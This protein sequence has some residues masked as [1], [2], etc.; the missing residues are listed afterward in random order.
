MT[1]ISRRKSLQLL[2]ASVASTLSGL[3]AFA[4]DWPSKPVS[5]VVGFAPG[6]W[7]D[8]VA[9]QIGQMLSSE[10]GQSVVVDNRAGASQ[11]IATSVVA[12]ARPDGHT[13]L[14]T[15]N[16]HF[17]NKLLI[18]G[19]SY[20]PDRDF[21]PVGGILTNPLVIYTS[22]NA[23]YESVADLIAA[24]KNSTQGVSFGSGGIGV[25]PHLIPELIAKQHATN[26]V[27]IPYRGGAPATTDLIAGQLAFVTDLY[28]AVMPYI[29]AGRV[30]PLAVTSRQRLPQ[31]PNV[32]TLAETVLPGF[33]ADGI[34][35]LMAP[36]GV[37]EPVIRQLNAG[38][39]KVLARKEVV[40]RFAMEGSKPLLGDP[41]SFLS[42]LK[43]DGER[44]SALINELNIQPS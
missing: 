27:H 19:L 43:K 29:A 30:K 28:Q 21:I 17:H 33:A 2:S 38:L 16:G 31:L 25:V 7:A 18:R 37:P 41:S 35:G 15:S 32:P 5:F 34:I 3:P 39:Q 42:L 9:R 22:A 36:S 13:L 40:E 26:F 10:I 12:K 20:D 1:V 24:G 44:W 11:T 6:G 23:P 8:T 4:A 14:V